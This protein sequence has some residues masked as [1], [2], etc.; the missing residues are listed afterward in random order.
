MQK[1]I[2]NEEAMLV[3]GAEVAAGAHLGMLIG[4]EG[5]LGA[6]KT[7]FCRGFLRHL[8]FT[9]LVKSPTYALVESYVLPSV[10]VHH[11]DL[12]RLTNAAELL[13]MGFE[14]YADNK[15]ILLIE[16]PERG[17]GVLPV[18]DELYHIDIDGPLRKV[19]RIISQ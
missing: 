2:D 9:G 15:S 7:V 3:F 12:Y 18:L 5:D 11:F 16:W 4:L 8:G 1:I 13:S 17:R 19:T 14:D 10:T 6:G